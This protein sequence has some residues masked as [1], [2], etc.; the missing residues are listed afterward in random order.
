VILQRQQELKVSRAELKDA[1][2]TR[3]VS[4]A[5]IKQRDADVQAASATRD[6][7]T[8]KF[9]RDKELAGR[10]TVVGSVV[11]EEERDYLASE[12]SVL[13][14]KANVERAKADFAESE[15][16]IEAAAADVELKNA[17]IVVAQKELDCAKAVADFGKIVAPFEGVVVRHTVDPGPFVQNATTGTSEPLISIAKVD[18]IARQLEVGDNATMKA[19]VSEW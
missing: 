1:K 12:A 8:R 16:K 11:E 10:N 4:A 9:E 17:Q 14:T 7:K 18:V 3:D 15:S 2:A 5:N 6:F 13:S 19:G